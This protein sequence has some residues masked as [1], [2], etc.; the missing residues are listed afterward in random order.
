MAG[1]GE[2]CDMAGGTAVAKLRQ[3]SDCTCK[4]HNKMA[5]VSPE[6]LRTDRS[7]LDHHAHTELQS[8][9]LRAEAFGKKCVGP[10][11]HCCR[12]R[13]SQISHPAR[14]SCSAAR[15]LISQSMIVQMYRPAFDGSTRV[16]Q[17]G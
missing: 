1:D 8:I 2:A 5:S 6:G 4:A 14:P 7:R 12:R 16:V 9:L 13:F 15:P 10:I 3:R 11:L 17:R